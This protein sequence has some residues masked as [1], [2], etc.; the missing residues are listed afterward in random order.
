MYVPEN[1][2]KAFE[3]G[4]LTRIDG[5]NK[6]FNPYSKNSLLYIQWLKGWTNQNNLIIR[7]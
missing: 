5:F 6:Y 3:E 1:I 2:N 7:N 4:V